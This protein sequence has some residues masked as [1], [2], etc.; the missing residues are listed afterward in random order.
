MNLSDIAKKILQED[1]WGTNPAAAGSMSPGAT[2][3][4]T[5]S[6]PTQ[7]GNVVDISQPF[8]NFKTEIEKQENATIKKFTDEIKKQFLKQTV[9]VNASK[10]SIGQIEKE[11]TILVLDVETRY[12]KDKY[13]VVFIGKEG[14]SGQSEYYLNKSE[15][16]VNP[17]TAAPQQS[18]L[19]NVGGV[20]PLKPTSN[21]APTA[22]NIL[23]QG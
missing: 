7:G 4:A 15:I 11:Y 1:S 10:G 12:M 13:Y 21:M 18:G 17:Q 16:K 2:P 14:K 9:T 22:K 6:K 3:V 23:P 20:V 5:T 8:A 19:K